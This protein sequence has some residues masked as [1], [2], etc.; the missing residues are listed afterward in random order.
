[1]I[2]IFGVLIC[3]I[4]NLFHRQIITAFINIESG[5]LAF[6][7]ANSYISFISWFFALIGLK[8]A[9]DGVLRGSGDVNVYMA[10]NLVNLGIR[11]LVAN[12]CAPIWGVQAVWYAIP[13]GWGVNFLISF[14]WYLTG[15]WS[16]KQIIS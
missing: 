2:G 4:L 3:L 8:A 1:M 15:R 11:V 14:S 16:R 13:M 6:T 7:T 9:T 5:H 10:A 12:L